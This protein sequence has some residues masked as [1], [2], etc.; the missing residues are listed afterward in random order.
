MMSGSEAYGPAEWNTDEFEAVFRAPAYDPATGFTEPDGYAEPTGYAEATSFADASWFLANTPYR[1]PTPRRADWY[2]R[3]DSRLPGTRTE[4]DWRDRVVVVGAGAA[5]LAAAD[6][7]RRLGFSGDVTVLGDETPYDRP[8]CSKG[9]LSG[10]QKLSDVRLPA[11]EAPID[12][13]LGL[14]AARLDLRDRSVI[15]EDGQVFGYDGLVIATG[16]APVVPDG[17]PVGEPGLHTLHTLQ[18]AWAIRQELYSAER[19]AIIGGGLTGC[20]AACAVRDLARDALIIDS[21]PCLMHRALGE[22]V[23]ALVTRAHQR[24]G[25]RTRLGRRVA[26]VERRRNRWRLTLDDGEYV[27]AD[28][29]LLTTGERP[30][31]GWLHGNGL[32][33]ADGV[34]CD[35][36]LRVVGAPGVV[37]AGVVARWPN[38][39]FADEPVRCGQWIAAMEQGRA[40]AGALLAGDRSVPPFTL[41]PRFWSQQGDLRIQACGAIDAQADVALTRLRPHRR[42]AARSGLVATFYRDGEMTGLVAVNA[43]HAFTVTTRALLQDIPPDVVPGA[44]HATEEPAAVDAPFPYGDT[45]QHLGGDVVIVR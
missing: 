20:E 44:H 14:R 45:S 10:H 36:N 7:L 6:E 11:L 39:R 2:D 43:P 18:D 21:K 16:A 29:V 32:D 15:T 3:V 42:D 17:W 34:L 38:L 28:L 41:L 13:R 26:E 23:G 25:I 22:T 9:V 1:P 33:L 40:A 4:F 27:V 5:G 24:A 19:V 8:A 12:L 37:A 31:T 35:A 30:D